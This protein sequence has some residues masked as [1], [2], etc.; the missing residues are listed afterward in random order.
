[1][2]RPGLSPRTSPPPGVEGE[3]AARHPGAVV[4][5]APEEAADYVTQTRVDFLAV[6]IGTV[7]GRL[8]G[9]PQLDL[10]RLAAIDAAAGVPLVIHGGT[11]LSDAQFRALI[12]RGVAKINY[13]TALADAAAEQIR[14]NVAAYPDGGYTALLRDI[15]TP[16]RLEIERCMRLWGSAGRAEELL[17]HCRPW[18]P[19]EHLIV[20][21][22][23]AEAVGNVPELMAEGRA[24]LGAIPGV[25]DVFTGTAVREEAAYRFCWNVRFCHPAVIASYRDHPAHRAFADGRFRPIAQNRISIDYLATGDAHGT[26]PP[27]SSA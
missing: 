25:R 10:D 16:L 27:D 5:T 8:R 6:S 18:R 14:A 15:Q 3:D 7:H 1:M 24:V 21:N 20:Y 17:T 4:Y 26:P 19:V 2:P 23:A 22:V 9:T 12:E 13:Y 11:G